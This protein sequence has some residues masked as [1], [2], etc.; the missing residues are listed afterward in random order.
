MQTIPGLFSGADISG[1]Y[2]KFVKI[3]TAD[4]Q[5]VAIVADTDK[6]IGVLINK[7]N[8]ANLG[9]TVVGPGNVTKM[10]YGGTITRGDSLGPDADGDAL[11][12]VEG[13]DTTKYVGAIALASGV[14]GDVHQVLLV[15]PHRAA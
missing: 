9:A 6:I 4:F 1:K 14:S 8:A 5:V 3:G 12:I 10:S 15:T 11:A 7:P 2:Q 13:T